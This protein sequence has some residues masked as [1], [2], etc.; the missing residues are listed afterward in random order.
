V[1]DEPMPDRRLVVRLVATATEPVRV[2]HPCRCDA[3]DPE[4]ARMEPLE[5][6]LSALRE[7]GRVLVVC[8]E[9]EYRLLVVVADAAPE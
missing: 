9:C 3:P 2:L 5:A 6:P 8:P 4:A 1:N 7:E